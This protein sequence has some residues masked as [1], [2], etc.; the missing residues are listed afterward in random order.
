MPEEEQKP[1]VN[2][3]LFRRLQDLCPR[4][5]EEVPTGSESITTWKCDSPGLTEVLAEALSRLR[6]HLASV[7]TAGAA[8]GPGD[9]RLRFLFVIVSDPE[10][11][12][13]I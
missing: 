7:E 6:K 5:R 10:A 11:V 4:S 2:E 13:V 12:M 3:K 9:R 1:R 8:E